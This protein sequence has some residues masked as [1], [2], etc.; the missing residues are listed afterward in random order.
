M[1]SNNSSFPVTDEQ[2]A[3]V[4]SL[5]NLGDLFG[6][7]INPLFIDRIG[8]KN[9]LLLFALPGLIGWTLIIFAQNYI[10]LYIAR[11]IAGIGQGSSFNTLIIYLTEISEKSIRGMQVNAM[12]IALSIGIFIFTSIAAFTSYEFLNISSASLLI[13]FL[14]IFPFL[15]E[16]PYYYLLRGRND[17][18]MQCLMKFR[19]ITSEEK[20]EAEML[21]MKLAVEEDRR[22]A[23]NSIFKEL[24]CKSYNRKGLIIMFLMKM[25]QL[26]SGIVA[27]SSYAQ[28]IFSY[29]SPSIDGG[30]Q[31][32]ILQ[33]ISLLASLFTNVLIDRFN[34]RILFLSTGILSSICLGSVGIFFFMNDYLKTNVSFIT[35]VPLVALV[36]FNVVYLVGIGTIPYIVQGELFPMNIKGPAV[37]C[38]MIVGSTFAFGTAA[39]YKALSNAAA[40]F[41][42]SLLTFWIT[43]NTTGMTLEE[44]QAMQNP[45]LREKL[46]LQ[47]AVKNSKSA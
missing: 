36:L 18:A 24:I 27:I 13:L 1:T 31:V 42:G 6:S 23:N 16:T 19:G 5:F 28:E 7:L 43:P 46:E 33:G 12:Q 47:R 3:W 20:L 38:G 34:R 29:S 30:V 11:F 32:I 41:I 37:A 35:W 26:L 4:V 14:L 10:Y 17:D 45:E 39:G 25:T 8:R 44:I 21:E 40:A 9:T 15:P 22:S 2:A